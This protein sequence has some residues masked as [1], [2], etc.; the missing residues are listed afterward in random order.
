MV[1]A[2][3]GHSLAQMPQP[4]QVLRLKSNQAGFSSTHCTGQYS[5]QTAHLTH[6][7][8]LTTGRMLRQSPGSIGLMTVAT[9]LRS[10]GT[11]ASTRL[12]IG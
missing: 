10:S 4:L 6:L 9:G 5:Q 3:C 1:I 8:R 11:L 2:R 7:S 12:N